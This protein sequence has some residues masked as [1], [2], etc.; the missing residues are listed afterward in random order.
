MTSQ[1][2]K[3]T[4]P[5]FFIQKRRKKSSKKSYDKEKNPERILRKR[6]QK[7]LVLPSCGHKRNF[8][9]KQREIFFQMF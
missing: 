1:V 3:Q 7:K 8:K 5:I 9:P 6:K 4:F 2:Q